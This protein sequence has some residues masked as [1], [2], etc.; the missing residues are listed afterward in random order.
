MGNT[1]VSHMCQQGPRR[2]C[3]KDYKYVIDICTTIET[4]ILEDNVQTAGGAW[5]IGQ[6]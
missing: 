6:K 1:P 5:E 4:E 3:S 2:K